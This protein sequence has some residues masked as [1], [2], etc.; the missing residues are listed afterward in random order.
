MRVRALLW[1]AAVAFAVTLAV[2]VGW[3]MSS[4]AMA[5][6][7]GVAAGVLASIPTSLI[8]V[9]V[10][11]RQWRAERE[12]REGQARAQSMPSQPQMPV[13]VIAPPAAP[14]LAGPATWAQSYAPQLPAAPRRQFT[15]IG[16]DA[17]WEDTQAA[18]AA[19]RPVEELWPS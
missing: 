8:V 19:R 5:V 13:V 7:V 12:G 4:E 14:S 3:R 2:I 6:L 10:T 18:P 16:Q 15:V 17:A 1:I 9:W 11:T